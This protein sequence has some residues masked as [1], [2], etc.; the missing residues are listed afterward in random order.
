MTGT[1]YTSISV[2]RFAPVIG[3]SLI[4]IA[5][6]SQPDVYAPPAQRKPPDPDVL[7]RSKLIV[8]MA[9]PSVERAIV[10]DI[11]GREKGVPWRWTAQHPTVSIRLK[12][13]A[14]LKY[15]IDFALADAIFKETG[16][17]SITY[18]VNDQV[19]DKV[20]YNTPG[21]KTFEKLIPAGMLR[22]MSENR[23]AAE[24]DKPKLNEDGSRLGFILVQI[25]LRP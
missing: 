5:C 18:F 15:F 23:L 14:N 7:I 12:S 8:D 22:P 16:P 6:V 13:A 24:I 25:G 20:T 11:L 21:R 4:A 2:F 3:F 19:L 10:K 9:E 1:R 17:V